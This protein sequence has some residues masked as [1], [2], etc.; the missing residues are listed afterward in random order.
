MKRLVTIGSGKGG[1]GKTWFAISLSHALARLGF[2]T[3]LIDGDVGLANVDVQLGLA[4]G[5]DLG[6]ALASENPIT[7]S[8]RTVQMLGL[9]VLAGRSGSGTTGVLDQYSAARMISAFRLLRESYELIVLDLPSGI[10]QGVRRLMMAADDAVIVTTEEPTALTDAY[11][12]MKAGRKHKPN[13]LPKIV[14][15]LVESHQ[16]GHRIFEGLSRVCDRFLAMKPLSLGAVRRDRRVVEAISRQT[17]LFQCYPNC[18]AAQ[19]VM[20]VAE[21]LAGKVPVR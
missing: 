3:L 4:N 16:A 2:R 14:V 8:I 9:D 17:P 21:T 7:T 6:T 15:N 1:V 10:D 13:L 12:L 5:P 19:D 18:D 11:A 20:A